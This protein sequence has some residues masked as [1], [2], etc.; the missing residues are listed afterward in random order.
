MAV[1]SDSCLCVGNPDDRFR[2]LLT[3]RQGVFMDQHGKELH[4]LWV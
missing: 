3:R 1:V 4:N 2:P